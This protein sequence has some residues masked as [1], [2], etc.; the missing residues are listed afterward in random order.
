MADTKEPLLTSKQ[1]L[2][3][4]GLSRATLNN[5]VAQGLLPKPEV[6]KP[7]E[8]DDRA[9]RLG[10]FPQS[11]LDTI[12]LISSLKRLGISMSHIVAML[13]DQTEDSPTDG[14]EQLET[15]TAVRT[16]PK[17]DKVLVEEDSVK[18]DPEAEKSKK[19]L[20]NAASLIP[21]QAW[22]S[23]DQFEFPSYLVNT[24][25]DLEWASKEAM[26]DILDI[27]EKL[28]RDITKRSIFGLILQSEAISGVDSREEILKLH[29][30]VA[31]KRLPKSSFL[32][33]GAELDSRDMQRLSGMFDDIDPV[34]VN[35]VMHSE[36]FLELKG[37]EPQW[38][39]VY[40]TIFREGFF[41]AYVPAANTNNDGL[42]KLL[43]R[44][45]VVIRDLLKRRQPYLT[46]LGVLV[47]DLQDSFKICSELPPEEYFELINDIWGAMAPKLRRFYATQGKHSGDGMVYYFFPQ[48]DCNYVLNAI[49]CAHEMRETIRGVSRTWQKKKNWMNELELNIGIDEGQ[50]WF[51][52]YQ[53]PTHLEFTVLGD[54]VNIASRLSDFA[55]SGSIFVTKNTLGRLSDQ[56]RD[57]VHYGIRR[58]SADG[59]D[60]LIPSTYSRIS[61]L[62]DVD[63]PKNEKL[64]D[65]AVLP[66][67]EILDVESPEVPVT[68]R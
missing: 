26:T 47:A 36:I 8:S 39:N 42:L 3:K 4:S 44:R 27:G 50:E 68:R 22:L 45:D 32:S 53:T 16:V 55:R 13:G 11:A 62:I 29:M 9:T 48:P 35:Q 20:K 59:T 41:F 25:F 15:E 6:K 19:T 38:Y 54:T 18:E 30:S 56:E 57:R 34:T 33:I 37:K 61:N 67:T 46:P 66:V 10:Y 40:T 7:E 24:S 2:E 64:R 28:S 65:I 52:T 14:L 12:N 31:K 60:M 43:A 49:R 51:G 5:Y 58:L 23:L 21:E 1:L 17:K 63:D